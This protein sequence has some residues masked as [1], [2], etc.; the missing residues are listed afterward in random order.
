MAR[1]GP[2]P[3]QSSGAPVHSGG[4]AFAYYTG[5]AV[6]LS[7]CVCRSK[8]TGT[9]QLYAVDLRAGMPRWQEISPKDAPEIG[10]RHYG[11][12]PWRK[13]INPDCD[14]RKMQV[15]LPQCMNQLRKVAGSS[16]PKPSHRSLIVVIL[17]VRILCGDTSP[18]Y[19]K[20]ASGCSDALRYGYSYSRWLHA[21]SSAVSEIRRLCANAGGRLHGWRRRAS[22]RSCSAARKTRCTACVCVCWMCPIYMHG[23]RSLLFLRASIIWI[24]PG[25]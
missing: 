8:N 21:R 9:R 13:V 20:L 7:P 6:H 3:P 1:G 12:F 23:R 18:L 10:Q 17:A 16:R 22:S 11:D 4:E 24:L 19:A 15:S 5:A 14:A 2:V 25:C